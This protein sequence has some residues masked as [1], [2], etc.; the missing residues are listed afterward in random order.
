MDG[1]ALGGADHA[2]RFPGAGGGLANA[3]GQLVQGRGGLFQAGGLLFSAA[4]Q[5]IGGHADLI[6]AG[7]D[8]ARGLRHQPHGVIE[9]GDGGVEVV[10]HAGKLRGQGR[11]EPAGEVAFRQLAQGRRQG[12]HGDGL[13]LF[14][15][16]PSGFRLH[17]FRFQGFEIDR[18]GQVHVQQGRLDEDRNR[19]GGVLRLGPPG[20]GRPVLGHRRV[21]ELLKDQG[22][23]ADV[24]LGLQ[25]QAGMGLANGPHALGVLVPEL[26]LGDNAPVIGLTALSPGHM[27]VVLEELLHLRGL[28]DLAVEDIKGWTD[29]LGDKAAQPTEPFNRAGVETNEF[30]TLLYLRRLGHGIRPPFCS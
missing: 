12:A 3:F 18:N 8:A 19:L 25:A 9:L 5:I 27:A 13:L 24:P 16:L 7:A 4:G 20:Q 14:G 22:V 11:V 26:A 15:L 28:A 6:G 1:L 30:E 2:R 23:A 21:D 17:P 29:G 10:L